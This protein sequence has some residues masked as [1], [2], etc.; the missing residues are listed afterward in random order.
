MADAD[1]V[2]ETASEAAHGYVFSRLNK[3]TVDDIDLAVSF[4][5]DVLEVEI[6]IVAPDADA[7]L[8]QIAED[9]VRV[10]GDAAD[11]LFDQ[12]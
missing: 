1:A 6:S 11:E 7:D 3:S 9:A 2:V 5:D 12:A 10:A 8:E 4:E